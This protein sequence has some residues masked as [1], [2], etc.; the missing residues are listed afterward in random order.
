MNLDF[1]EQLYKELQPYCKAIYLGGSRVDPIIK[2]PH[3]YD[4]VIFTIPGVK[5]KDIVRKV[6]NEKRKLNLI[7]RNHDFI[8]I[9]D[10]SNIK[11][12]LSSY[13]YKYCSKIV[14]E[15]LDLNI[16]ILGKYKSQFIEA[17]KKK[18]EIC[19]IEIP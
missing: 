14:G 4:I 17:I 8:D 6:L 15:E 19:Q 2:K 1:L 13:L 7:P 16:D 5:P 9:V 11:I 18:A 10:Y 3:D 12:N